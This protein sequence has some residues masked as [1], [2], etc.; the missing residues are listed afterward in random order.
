[1]NHGSHPRTGLASAVVAVAACTLLGG[2]SRP[3]IRRVEVAS[4]P[5]ERSVVGRF[6]GADSEWQGE[7][8]ADI[9]YWDA[10]GAE[11]SQTVAAAAGW[12]IEREPAAQGCRLHC[13]QA[14]LGL[15]I[16]LVFSA[17]GDVLSVSACGPNCRD[18]PSPAEV[19]AAVAAFRRRCRGR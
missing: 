13:R 2:S 12:T 5:T 16:G 1:M 10:A 3:G 11:H 8:L 17:S 4:G 19:A 18:R 9:A 15:A 6:R 14:E 7:H